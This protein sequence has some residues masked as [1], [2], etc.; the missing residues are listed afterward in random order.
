[1]A[2]TNAAVTAG[3]LL[4]TANVSANGTANWVSPWPKNLESYEIT[5]NV[6]FAGVPGAASSAKKL[7]SYGPLIGKL[8]VPASGSFGTITVDNG[9]IT[10]T[11]S[12]SPIRT[13]GTVTN[14]KY[15]IVAR[16]TYYATTALSTFELF[17]DG[18]RC[19][20]TTGDGIALL[21]LLATPAF[22]LGGDTFTCAVSYD[23]IRIE[24][25]TAPSNTVCDGG[26]LSVLGDGAVNSVACDR[27]ITWQ[28]G[29]TQEKGD[30][31]GSYWQVKGGQLMLSRTIDTSLRKAPGSSILLSSLPAKTGTTT[32][33]NLW[34]LAAYTGTGPYTT[35]DSVS[36]L[37]L[38][39][40]SSGSGITGWLGEWFNDSV[41][42]VTATGTSVT[43]YGS[44]TSG[45][46]QGVTPVASEVTIP[47]GLQAACTRYV[48]L[49][50]IETGTS[51]SGYG[52][53]SVEAKVKTSAG[54][55]NIWGIFTIGQDY[56]G[57]SNGN[58][59]LLYGQGSTLI[60][61][62][63]T[64]G[65]ANRNL[66]IPTSALTAAF[67]AASVAY[68]SNP[69]SG[70]YHTYKILRKANATVGTVTTPSDVMQFWYDGVEIT[71]T[72]GSNGITSSG[73]MLN[74]PIGSTGSN[75]NLMIGPTQR[76]DLDATSTLDY[77]R[78][79]NES[80]V[81]AVPD[82]ATQSGYFSTK[83]GT[84]GYLTSNYSATGIIQGAS[85]LLVTGIVKPI[86]SFLTATGGS[87][88]TGDA[89]GTTMSAPFASYPNSTTA[90]TN[91]GMVELL[92]IGDPT[93]A[94]KY[95]SVW[96]W[97]GGKILMFNGT[98]FTE[99]NTAVVSTS[100][101]VLGIYLHPTDTTP[102]LYING[103]QITDLLAWRTMANNATATVSVANTGV[104]LSSTSTARGIYLGPRM[105]LYFRS[106]QTKELVTLSQDSTQKGSLKLVQDGTDTILQAIQPNG[107]L[108]AKLT[109]GA[110]QLTMESTTIID[111]VST[112]RKVG[113]TAQGVVG[114]SGG[115]GG[116][117]GAESVIMNA[118][119]AKL[120]GLTADTQW[121]DHAT[122][123]MPV[124]KHTVLSST[125]RDLV[126]AGN[127]VVSTTVSDSPACHVVTLGELH[128]YVG[129]GSAVEGGDAVRVIG[130]HQV[131]FFSE[132]AT[133]NLGVH[134]NASFGVTG[135][136]TTRGKVSS[137]S[138]TDLSLESGNQLRLRGADVVI[139]SHA[140][141][142]IY[143][144]KAAF[145]LPEDETNN[146][147]G[148][149]E[150]AHRASDQASAIILSTPAVAAPVDIVVKP[151]TG[152]FGAE[153]ET[154]E[155][156][157]G[158]VRFKFTIVGGQLHVKKRVLSSGLPDKTICV[159]DA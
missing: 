31:T 90:A 72:V 130:Q 14:I 116:L 6:S 80:S 154:F 110:D 16:R 118:S 100:E 21:D 3:K 36:G 134:H 42:S 76:R 93:T 12:S 153:A 18:V 79:R 97:R 152:N 119:A 39:Y 23:D 47:T 124:P 7:F 112:T 125:T 9:T 107:D 131:G 147:H 111:G 71:L 91:V 104:V 108:G 28:K 101:F 85:G 126:L 70:S 105:S 4:L 30:Y 103:A 60:I 53:W 22:V 87:I 40:L 78:F 88:G 117:T 48:T 2:P 86:T 38:T 149:L 17:V 139:D 75:K 29:T 61:V 148:C 67:T 127:G 151:A 115:S 109:I 141:V 94:G 56:S 34:K 159:F 35:A 5:F 66:L 1:M 37:N 82:H 43:N 114:L 19:I 26:G 146:P 89:V 49:S 83:Y 157:S 96:V 136:S 45:T 41:N 33:P 58:Q 121:V 120:K 50:D 52:S 158:D 69:N 155:L 13:D 10:S 77:I 73:A 8:N 138:N 156:G 102:K 57:G 92:T 99:T 140:S 24:L 123:Q 84:T 129:D 11:S 144:N 54:S 74:V 122:A 32:E 20:S 145:V 128:A 25:V 51:T 106:V 63:E 95:L 142:K 59:I 15:K 46:F 150:I 143:P 133:I 62:T 65:N 68:T 137:T 132:L 55:S 113:V 27:S 135:S 64:S 81:V 98:S 44:G